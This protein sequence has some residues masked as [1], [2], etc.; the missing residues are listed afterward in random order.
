[1][2]YE[3][4]ERIPMQ[5]LTFEGVQD[6]SIQHDEKFGGAFI[7]CWIKDQTTQN[8][9]YIAKG[10][11]EDEGWIVLELND[12]RIVTDEDYNEGHDGR[13]YYEQA[14]IDEEVFFFHTFSKKGKRGQP[15]NFRIHSFSFA[16]FPP[17]S[18]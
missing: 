18:S 7:N 6:P 3:L 15:M 12:H 5:F 9:I 14:L 13:E 1:M 10:C 16:Q 17:G 2:E 4:H 11:I 8:A